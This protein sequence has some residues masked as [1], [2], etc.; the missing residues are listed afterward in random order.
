VGD[1]SGEGPR[2]RQRRRGAARLALAAGVFALVS[3]PLGWT[4]TD[5]LERDND[6]CNA[7]HLESGTPLHAEVRA[8]FDARPAATLAAAHAGVRIEGREDGFRCIDCHG[9]ASLVGRARVKVLAAKDAFWYVVGSFEE[10]DG[11]RWP[12]WDE[13][14]RKC[15]EAFDEAPA[16]TWQSPRF[17]QVPLHNVE[18]GV[19]C[20]RCH[21]VH[22][23]GGNT[24][25]HFIHADSVRVECA[26]CH[27][28]FEE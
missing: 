17:H 12:L 25:A 28:E 19:D 5:R 13:D 23:A 15:H 2:G 24:S 14:C 10:P 6:F 20:V 4:V 16:S 21:R 3:A 18:L 27:P 11:M 22:D 8:A 26:R 7:C 1:A 9:G